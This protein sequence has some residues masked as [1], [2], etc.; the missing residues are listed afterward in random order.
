[1]QRGTEGKVY[2]GKIRWSKETDYEKGFETQIPFRSGDLG[3][4]IRL[5]QKG[6]AGGALERSGRFS[7]LWKWQG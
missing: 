2:E 3:A 1:M 5:K 4:K 7:S 6:G